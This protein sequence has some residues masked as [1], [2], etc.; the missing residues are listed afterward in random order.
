MRFRPLLLSSLLA[1]ASAPVTAAAAPCAG[2]TDVVDTDYFCTAAEWIKNRGVTTGC[3]ATE[4]CPLDN[5][6]RAQMALFM[7]RLGKALTPV[8][9]HKQFVVSGQMA[10]PGPMPGVLL[11][12]TDDLPAGTFPRTAKLVGTFAATP[13]GDTWLQGYFRYSTDAG[14]T[15]TTVG[16][17]GVDMWPGRDWAGYGQVAGATVLA[18]PLA[19][20]PA[21]TY[22]FS[23]WLNGMNAA[24]PYVVHA[25]ICQI[26]AT[27]LSA[28]PA[29]PPLDQ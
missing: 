2:F 19:L 8:T 12:Q 5:V 11:C 15:W 22:R 7:H 26:D 27:I 13:D 23:L 17:Y 20:A 16:N 14:A 3:S 1:L 29:S 25:L 10:I 6:T 28:N 9:L 24:A 4:Y 21:T 18:P